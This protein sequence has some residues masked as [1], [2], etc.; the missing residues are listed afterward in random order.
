MYMY[1]LILSESPPLNA[2]NSVVEN[3]TATH[4]VFHLYDIDALLNI[5]TNWLHLVT[6]PYFGV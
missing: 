1:Y 2:P 6:V 4:P 5:S 3:F